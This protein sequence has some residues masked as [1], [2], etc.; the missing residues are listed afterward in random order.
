MAFLLGSNPAYLALSVFS[1]LLAALLWAL[2][3]KRSFTVQ[4]FSIIILSQS[5]VLVIGQI[6][7]QTNY[8]AI[9]NYC[10]FQAFAVN[11]LF[12]AMYGA[13]LCVYFDWYQI[14]S[15][16]K[17]L[18]QS[19]TRAKLQR[20]GYVAVVLGVPFIVIMALWGVSGYSIAGYGSFFCDTNSSLV[21]VGGILLRVIYVVCGLVLLY[22]TMSQFWSKIVM[23]FKSFARTTS[24]S[25]SGSTD[26]HCTSQTNSEVS[27]LA[28]SSGN[29]FPSQPQGTEGE[30]P[31]LL[32]RATTTLARMSSFKQSSAVSL[33][34]KESIKTVSRSVSSSANVDSFAP[35]ASGNSQR[36]ASDRAAP[37][38][39][40]KPKSYQTT[41]LARLGLFCFSYT[42]VAVP[43]V[44]WETA[45]RVYL[46]REVFFNKMTTLT[47]DK[48]NEVWWYSSTP[49]P[50]TFKNPYTNASI[51]INAYMLTGM[52]TIGAA[53]STAAT[54]TIAGLFCAACGLFL[55]FG[56]GRSVA[57]RYELLFGFVLRPCRRALSCTYL[58]KRK[59]DQ[60][61]AVGST[62]K[63]S[64]LTDSELKQINRGTSSLNASA[65]LNSSFARTPQYQKAKAKTVFDEI[66]EL[67]AE[68]TACSANAKEAAD[69]C[70]RTVVEDS[71]E[72][73]AEESQTALDDHS[74]SADETVINESKFA[75]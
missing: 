64:Q 8:G 19:S 52:S 41:L 28:I 38:T 4:L 1:G 20:L 21:V 17:I 37:K 43:V 35:N 75:T 55:V 67:E 15:A 47:D 26:Q 22:L 23:A 50:V 56:T 3:W 2:N 32:K 71:P 57:A 9:Y 36:P 13:A 48:A 62:I 29:G 30:K 6:V 65:N 58:G 49:V 10:H 7:N 34:A 53:S 59:G 72:Q 51:G 18:D 74:D 63:K 44:I 45:T 60:A 46:M 5:V 25:S 24:A 39:V 11:V 14:I 73:A 61:A 31:T 12:T 33:S 66:D 70:L 54:V 40:K 42:C 68:E 27:K 16:T 69:S